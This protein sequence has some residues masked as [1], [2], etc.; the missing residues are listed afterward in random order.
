MYRTTAHETVL[1]KEKL[2]DRFRELLWRDSTNPAQ[3]AE[4]ILI[5]ELLLQDEKEAFLADRLM[6]QEDIGKLGVSWFSIFRVF[7]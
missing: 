1:A 3:T 7:A 4:D 5:S 2:V 6:E